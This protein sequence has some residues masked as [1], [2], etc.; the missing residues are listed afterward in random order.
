HLDNPAKQLTELANFT[1][2]MKKA[3][4]I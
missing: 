4:K 2:A 3:T 1:Q